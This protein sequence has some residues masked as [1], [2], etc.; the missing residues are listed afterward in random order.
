MITKKDYDYLLLINKMNKKE[1]KTGG[2]NYDRIN[3][4]YQKNIGKVNYCTSCGGN[5][6]RMLRDVLKWFNE[7][8]FDRESL[9]D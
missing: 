1:R 8:E 7:K 5:R 4:I 9:K 2:V 6:N 3:R